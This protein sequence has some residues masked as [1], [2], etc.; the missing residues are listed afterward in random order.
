MEMYYD[1]QGN[2][3]SMN[4]WALKFEDVSYRRIAFD[5][6]SNGAE[7]STVWLGLNH[8]FNGG[9]PLIFETMVFNLDD[10]GDY[11]RRYSTEQEALKGHKNIV[12]SQ[13]KAVSGF[14]GEDK[15]E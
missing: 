6:L 11:Q 1:R 14:L 4:E 15:N 3:I 5:K 10:N 7:V 8:N 12:C 2:P 9:T 13:L